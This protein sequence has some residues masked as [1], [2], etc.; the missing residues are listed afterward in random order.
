MVVSMCS[1]DEFMI[2]NG[3]RYNLYD[4]LLPGKGI[5]TNRC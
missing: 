3:V 5:V 1:Y 2:F 4:R